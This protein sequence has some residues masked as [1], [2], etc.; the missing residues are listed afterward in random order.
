MKG[1]CPASSGAGKCVAVPQK[2]TTLGCRMR[3]STVS[4]SSISRSFVCPPPPPQPRPAPPRGPAVGC[5]A[6]EAGR[7]VPFEGH[8]IMFA[9]LYKRRI[10]YRSDCS[11]CGYQSCLRR[12]CNIFHLHKHLLVG[13]LNACRPHRKS[14]FRHL[15]CPSKRNDCKG[16]GEGGHG[17]FSPVQLPWRQDGPPTSSPPRA[18]REGGR[19][20]RGRGGWFTGGRGLKGTM[21]AADWKRRGLGGGGL[22]GLVGGGRGTKTQGPSS[23]HVRPLPRLRAQEGRGRGW[24]EASATWV[25][26]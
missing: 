8:S 24:G 23:R 3:T 5:L 18:T 12:V 9:A 15:V 16:R 25:A 22:C 14:P 13:N 7:G 17:R 2:V 1:S 26:P 10:E 4:S 6:E 21:S 11:P 20:R 19:G